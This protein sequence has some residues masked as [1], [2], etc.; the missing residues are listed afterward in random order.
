MPIASLATNEIDIAAMSDDAAE[1]H[2]SAAPY[3]STIDSQTNR[4]FVQRYHDRFGAELPI[5]AGA[6]SAYFQVHL[7]ANA[8]RKANKNSELNLENLV[9]ALSQI[10]FEAPQGRIRIDAET[11]HTELWPRIGR[12]DAQRRFDIVE[13]SPQA[14]HPV[15]Y[16]IHYDRSPDNLQINTDDYNYVLPET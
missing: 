15:P 7:V 16:L 13:A 6:E 2:L 1:G 10:A 12:V 9:T 14:I 4:H 5:S 11:H 8:A 3:F